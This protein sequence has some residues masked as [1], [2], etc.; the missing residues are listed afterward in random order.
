MPKIN[1]ISWLTNFIL[2]LKI[3]AVTPIFPLSQPP[4]VNKGE[5]IYPAAPFLTRRS[6]SAAGG[7]QT[8]D[9]K[10]DNGRGCDCQELE[11][12]TSNEAVRSKHGE[13]LGKYSKMDKIESGLNG[14]YNGRPGY[15]HESGKFFLYYNAGKIGQESSYFLGQIQYHSK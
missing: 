5:V 8:T 7:V 2:C 9:P 1:K 10:S 14:L 12:L 4:G 15:K 11:I 6:N 13:L 3:C